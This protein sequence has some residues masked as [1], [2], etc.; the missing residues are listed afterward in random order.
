MNVLVL[1]PYLQDTAPCQRFRIEQWATVLEERGVSFHFESFESPALKKVLYRRGQL[2]AKVRAGIGCVVSRARWLNRLDRRRWDAIFLHRELLPVGPPVLEWLLARTGVPIIYDFDD[3][4]FLPNVSD[5][6]RQ[7]AWLK[8][9]QKAGTI[10][11]LATHVVAGNEYLR[12]YASQFNA[13]ISVVPTTIDTDAYTVKES[14]ALHDPPVIGWTGSLTTIKHLETI[15]EA[16]KELRK[17]LRFRFKVFG[18]DQ[19]AIPGLEVESVPWTAASEIANLK[20]FDIGIMPLP[21]DDWSRGKCGLKA[22]Q[23]MALGIPVVASAVGANSEIITDGR[24][25]F[26]AA[27]QSEW[28]EKLSRLLKDPSL[29]I[30][31]AH[32]GR[33]TIE[34]D[35]SARVQAPRVLEILEAVCRDCRQ[36]VGDVRVGDATRD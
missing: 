4:I 5:A 7:L 34:A 21:D 14:M 33:K 13:R 3:A 35:Y 2:A 30:E 9:P 8:W 6:N 15:T 26:L 29:R 28:V 25:G 18:A 22:L 12:Q 36:P 27:S 20:E 17:S 24:D 10:C 16:L 32:Q 11:R 1:V 23:Y 19:F 31:F